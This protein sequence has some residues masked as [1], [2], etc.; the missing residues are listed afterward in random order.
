MLNFLVVAIILTLTPG[1]DIV[2][3]MLQSM[4][5]SK[6]NAIATALGLCTG[7]IA[8]TMAAVLGISALIY[9]SAFAFQLVKWAGAVYLLYLAWQ[10]LKESKTEMG[11][12]N[13][14]SGSF[15]ELYRKGIF[16]NILNPKVSLFFLALFP[17][18]IDPNRGSVSIQMAMLGFIFIVQA[19]LVFLLVSI[20]ANK[21]GRHLLQS[22]RATRVINQVKA[23]VFALLGIRLAF[24]E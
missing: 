10:A 9:Q 21:I 4:T 23:G 17:Q 14:Q 6:K 16:M 5:H 1:P 24:L 19:F 12:E 2:F 20:F 22:V 18:F 15:G 7:L 3:V 13:V 8:H 11:S